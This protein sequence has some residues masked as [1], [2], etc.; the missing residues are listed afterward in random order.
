MTAGAARPEGERASRLLGVAGWSGS[1]KTT[2]ITRLLP[3]LTARGLSVSTLKHVHHAVDLDRPGKDT[4]RHREAGAVEV[5]MVSQ[6]RWALLHELRGADP[7]PL[8]RLLAHLSPVDLV[9]AEGF[10]TAPHPKIEVHRPA[11]GKP[12]L[13]PDDPM[14]IAVASDAA[15]PGCP[16]PVLPLDAPEAIADFVCAWRQA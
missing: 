16:L 8:D 5:M 3:L 4:F 9:L 2:L 14:V 10:K 12:A 6:D 13:Y 11:L 1:G 7:P 15:L